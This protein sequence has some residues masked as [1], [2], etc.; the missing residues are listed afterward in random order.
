MKNYRSSTG[1]T[2]ETI[3]ELSLRLKSTDAVGEEI[4]KATA[5]EFQVEVKYEF[6][7]GFGGEDGQADMLEIKGIKASANVHFEGTYSE[8]VM[9]R[10]ADL[11]PLF[12]K[13]ELIK[14]EEKIHAA[15]VA[16]INDI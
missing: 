4:D 6:T 15:L 1:T 7:P 9:K 8:V 13:W 2:T 11:T 5:A 3:G 16:G 12:A 14:L 10:G